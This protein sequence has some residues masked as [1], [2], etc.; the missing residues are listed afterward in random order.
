MRDRDGALLLGND[1]GINRQRGA[2]ERFQPWL[3]DAGSQVIGLQNA[4]DG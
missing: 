4:A 3:A 1:A 2:D